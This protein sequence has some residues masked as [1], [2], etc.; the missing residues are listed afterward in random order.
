MHPIYHTK[1]V[2]LRSQPVGE[3]NKRYWLFTEELG[4]VVAVATGVRKHASKLAG[5]L[6]EDAGAACRVAKRLREAL[7]PRSHGLEYTERR[8]QRQEVPSPVVTWHA[9]LP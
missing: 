7:L 9:Y 5:Q 3:A 1:A 6:A 2:I 4:L 8:G